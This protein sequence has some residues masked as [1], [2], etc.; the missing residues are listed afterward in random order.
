L[1]MDASRKDLYQGLLGRG[2]D[3]TRTPNPDVPQDASDEYQLLWAT[4]HHRILFTFNIRDYMRIAQKHPY[5]AGISLANQKSTRI[6]QLI[7][8]LE[9]MLS[10]T[11]AEDWTGQIRWISEWEK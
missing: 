9:R 8:M 10:E 4:S 3:I 7:S 2:F 5:H 11:N 1:D 6:T